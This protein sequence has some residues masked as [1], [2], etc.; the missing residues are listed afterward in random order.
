[1]KADALSQFLEIIQ[2]DKQI[3]PVAITAW[4]TSNVT[5]VSDT[6]AILFRTI[7]Y[8]LIRHPKSMRRL[9]D[10]LD[11]AARNGELSPPVTW[12]ESRQLPYLDACIKKAARLHPP[13]AP[14]FERVV[15]P[16]GATICGR[17]FEAGTVVAI[18]A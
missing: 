9:L 3:P 17:R 10:E 12:K 13:F 6:T 18:P 2:K 15:P 11:K 5:A 4:T 14:P 7:F 1:M 8:N 16:G